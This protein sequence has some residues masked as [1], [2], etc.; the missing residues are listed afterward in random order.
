MNHLS[1]RKK[2]NLFIG[3]LVSFMIFLLS[4]CS[5][6]TTKSTWTIKH[7]AYGKGNI[8][9]KPYN[10]ASCGDFTLS[11]GGSRSVT[12]EGHGENYYA[13]KWEYYST[14]VYVKEYSA[15]RV[16]LFTY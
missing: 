9:V 14:G 13:F 8:T 3:L 1:N 16:L 15:S 12:W 5:E 11:P 2:V 6:F 10:D 7:G 4:S